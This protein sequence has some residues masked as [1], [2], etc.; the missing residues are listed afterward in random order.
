MNAEGPSVIQRTFGPTND[1]VFVVARCDRKIAASELPQLPVAILDPTE[2]GVLVVGPEGELERHALL[3]RVIGTVAFSK[4]GR[5][6]LKRMGEAYSGWFGCEPPTLIDIADCAAGRRGGKALSA[7]LAQ[8]MA[9]QSAHAEQR[10]RLRRELVQLR[11]AHELALENFL[12]LERFVNDAGLAKR[13]EV[14]SLVPSAGRHSVVL[15]DGEQVRQRLPVSSAGL[16]DFAVHVAA[17]PDDGDGALEARLVTMENETEV[18]RWS[19][20][21]KRLRAGWQR[22]ALPVAL[23]DDPMSVELHVRWNGGGE[24]GLTLSMRHPDPRHQARREDAAAGGV[25]CMRL[26]TYLAG[27][28]APMQLDV[29]EPVRAETAPAR[30]WPLNRRVLSREQLMAARHLDGGRESCR[31]LEDIGALLVH[32]APRQDACALLADAIPAGA[33]SVMARA[34]TA[35]PRPADIEYRIAIAPAAARPLAATE[36]PEFPAEVATPWTRLRAEE[37]A[38]LWLAWPEPLA[39]PHDLYLITRM[40]DDIENCEWAWATFDRIVAQW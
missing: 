33:T 9:A 8:L 5:C 25:L 13:T 18:A 38:D 6:A 4:E 27:C 3:T 32:P 17:V 26:W 29:H 15:R 14:L 10:V 28:A 20:A 40:A 23:D 30:T 21:G 19:V 24:L 2:D 39:E 35:D 16:A 7:V 11:A 22:F 36:P 37:A 12:K 34:R 31:Y 1:Q